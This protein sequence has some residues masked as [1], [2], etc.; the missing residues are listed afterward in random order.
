LNLYDLNE[1]Y[2]EA[3]DGAID[4]NGEIKS[5][6]LAELLGEVGEELDKKALN[7]AVFIKNLESDAEQIKAEIDRL[8]DRKKSALKKAES[9]ER[10]LASVLDGRKFK[11]ARA[12]ISWRKSTSVNVTCSP[13]DLAS[14]YPALVKIKTEFQPIKSDIKTM[15]EGGELVLGCELIT[16]SNLVIK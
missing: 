4:E 5:E 7:I 1:M 13:E 2:S 6:I 8:N 16:R 3:L 15:I 10:Y 9:L 12:E 11:D 14:R